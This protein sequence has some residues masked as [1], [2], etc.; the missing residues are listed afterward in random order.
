MRPFD[1]CPADA[2]R[3]LDRDHE[4]GKLCPACERTWYQS[5]A[6]TAG[7]A[8]V[9]EGKAL[10]SIRAR[11]PEKGRMD[12]PGGFLAPGEQV[13]DGL[14]REVREELGIEVDA[15]ISDCVSAVAH[16]Y[17]PEGDFVLALGFKARLVSGEPQPADDVAAIRWVSLEDLDDLDFAWE[18]DREL[19][20]RALND[21]AR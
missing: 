4:G 3:L 11:D 19:V 14:K 6:P 5:S 21:E 20:R 13:I 7:A 10:V 8:I 18:H 9:K 1:F 16:T 2:T 15:D 12:V 17:G